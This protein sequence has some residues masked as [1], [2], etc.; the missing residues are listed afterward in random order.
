[1][2]TYEHVL[3]ATDL[4]PNSKFVSE[5]ASEIAKIFDAKFSLM[6]VIEPVPV[7]GYAYAYAG[8]ADIENELVEE[9]KK[10]LAELGDELNVPVANQWVEKGPTKTILLDMVAE[11]KVDL[12]VVGSHGRHGLGKLLGSTAN[13]VLNSAEIDVLTIRYQE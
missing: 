11:L 7:Y 8:M 5:K 12:L 3:V 9:A 1:M 13:A 10:A 6:H 2:K 4:L